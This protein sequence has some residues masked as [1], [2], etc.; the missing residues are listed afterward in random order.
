LKSGGSAG[1]NAL[2]SGYRF[3]D[4]TYSGLDA[5][6]DIW[7]SKGTGSFAW[8]RDFNAGAAG[9]GRYYNSASYGFAIRCLRD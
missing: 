4:G 1:F 2:T 8:N 9:A 6:G 3:L 5:D 7:S